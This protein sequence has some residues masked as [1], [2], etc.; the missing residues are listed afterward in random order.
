MREWLGSCEFGLT[1]CRASEVGLSFLATNN[2]AVQLSCS[3]PI[4]TTCHAHLRYCPLVLQRLW[5]HLA[6][7]CRG[8]VSPPR[9]SARRAIATDTTMRI[10]R[11]KP[12]TL[13]LPAA[14][15]MP[16]SACFLRQHFSCVILHVR[17]SQPTTELC[18]SHDLTAHHSPYVRRL[19]ELHVRSGQPGSLQLSL[20]NII[21]STPPLSRFTL[22]FATITEHALIRPQ[23]CFDLV[24]HMLSRDGCP[25]RTICLRAVSRYRL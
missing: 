10:W 24:Q 22:W 5:R 7:V 25:W 1:R 21:S 23:L 17:T 18:R 4:L 16:A 8:G 3:H 15:I 6:A 20:Y 12:E 2:P 14:F 9:P 13:S 11:L 19:S